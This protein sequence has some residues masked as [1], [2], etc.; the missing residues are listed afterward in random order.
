MTG[1]VATWVVQAI[2]VT[3]VA[4]TVLKQ[5]YSQGIIPVVEKTLCGQP[6]CLKS[7]FTE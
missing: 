6:G 2:L 4:S 1:I 5:D 3:S 7:Y